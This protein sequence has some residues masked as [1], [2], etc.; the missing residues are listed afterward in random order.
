MLKEAIVHIGLHKTGTTSIQQFVQDNIN[1][2]RDRGVDFYQGMAILQNHVELHAAAMRPER[3]SGYK[4]R[5]GLVVNDMY[6]KSV[7]ERVAQFIKQSPCPKVLFSS[8]GLSLLRYPDEVQMLKALLGTENVKIIVALRNP[9]DYLAS[10]EH[11]LQ[12]QPGTLP[13]EITKDSF[14][15]T[16]ADSWLVG[17][18]ARLEVFKKVFGEK[19]LVTIDYDRAMREDRNI[20]PAFLNGLGMADCVFVNNSSTY[21]LNKS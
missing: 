16:A 15:Y 5:T 11:Q 20:I 19:S 10:Y 14:A 7:K 1:G 9:A 13:T 8:E 4:N 2:F 18:E 12:K 21:Q 6:I 17:Y 3:Q